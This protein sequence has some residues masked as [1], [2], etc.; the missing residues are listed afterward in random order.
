MGKNIM[1]LET[2]KKYRLTKE[3]F[4]QVQADLVE[5]KA[6]FLGTDFEENNLYGNEFLKEKDAVLRLR[7]IN[8]I[9][10]LTYKEFVPNTLGV[11]QH[12]EHET[13]VENS[14]EIEEIIGYLGLERRIVYEKRRKKWNFRQVEVVLD[15]LPFGLYMEIE[16]AITAIAEAEMFLGADEFEIEVGTYPFLTRHLGVRVENRIESR[17]ASSSEPRDP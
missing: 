8:D 2:E 16:G 7:K 3:Q 5:L 4:E 15:E 1:A 11:K 10:I 13:R 12:I 9:T 14:A 6:Q 17:F